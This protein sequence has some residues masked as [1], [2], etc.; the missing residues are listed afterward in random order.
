MRPAG[1]RAAAAR[2]LAALDRRGF[3]RLLAGAAG[4]GLLPVACSDA[5]EGRAPPDGVELAL[6][7]PRSYAVLNAA[8]ARIAGPRGAALVHA[9]A[10]DPARVAD[11]FLA[12]SPELAAPLAQALLGLEFAVWPL[13]G[14]LRPFTSL[15]DPERDAI[16]QE[17][18]RSRLEL[19]R[20][21]F[22]GLRS[23]SLLG[24]Y[25]ALAEQRPAGFDLGAIPPAARIADA[26]RWQE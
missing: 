17:L 24:F 5:P 8:A 2:D 25:G 11:R 16:L 19:K 3:L 26:M 21:A 18:M 4:A 1:L 6:L 7:S 12:D 22:Q 15:D 14:K 9:G 23:V 10:L 20:M 13:L